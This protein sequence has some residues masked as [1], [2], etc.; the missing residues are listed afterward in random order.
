MASAD[1]ERV[2]ERERRAEEARKAWEDHTKA[3]QDEKAKTERLRAARLARE[4]EQEMP[5]KRSGKGTTAA[6]RD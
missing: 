3:A 5:R 6:E 2:K 1:P 4:A